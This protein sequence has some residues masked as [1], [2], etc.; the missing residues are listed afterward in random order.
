MSSGKVIGTVDAGVLYFGIRNPWA[1][2]AREPNGSSAE[3]C[4]SNG[5]V[6]KRTR[7]YEA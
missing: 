4:K 3:G 5:M 2:K 6:Q 7:Q 1:L